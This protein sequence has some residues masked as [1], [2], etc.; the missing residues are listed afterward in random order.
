MQTTVKLDGK[1]CILS[2]TSTEKQ[3]PLHPAAADAGICAVITM[4]RLLCGDSFRATEIRIAHH[5]QS[6]AQ[7]LE[8]FVQAPLSFGANANV[9]I[10]DRQYANRQLPTSNPE[11]ARINEQVAMNYMNE[12]D[13][14]SLSHQVQAKIRDLL[15]SGE[16]LEE[17]VAKLLNMSVRTMLRR[18]SEEGTNYKSLLDQTRQELAQNY[19]LDS[20]LSINEIA[21]LVG[22]A[23][24]GNFTL[25]FRRWYGTSPSEYR[26]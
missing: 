26:K 25:V 10:F 22:F 19:L 12:L 8:A 6:C 13:L 4:C 21:Y 15:P 9:I 3:Y 17:I 1:H 11:L 16:A 7:S 18:L 5:N 23:E 14:S 24:Q 2:F 20:Q